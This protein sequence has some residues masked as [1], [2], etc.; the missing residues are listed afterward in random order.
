MQLAGHHCIE[1]RH[2]VYTAFANLHANTDYHVGLGSTLSPYVRA[3]TCAEPDVEQQRDAPAT[4]VEGGT[5]ERGQA[6]SGCENFEVSEPHAEED[7]APE[8]VREHRICSLPVAELVDKLLLR[9]ETEDDPF[10]FRMILAIMLH[11]LSSHYILT[12]VKINVFCLGLH[13]TLGS[14]DDFMFML[15]AADQVIHV[16]KASSSTCRGER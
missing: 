3:C 12:A 4:E 9:L 7:R 15:Q 1:V 14:R 5:L 8:E 16:P 2:L 10:L 11:Y 13:H 6:R